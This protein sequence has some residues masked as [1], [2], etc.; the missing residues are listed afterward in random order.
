MTTALSGTSTRAE[1]DHQQQEAEAEHDGDEARQPLAEVVGEVDARGVDPPTWTSTSASPRAG[2]RRAG[3]GPVRSVASSCGAV[4]GT[5]MEMATSPASGDRR[6]GPRATL[7]VSRD[8]RR[9]ARRSSAGRR[10]RR[11]DGEHERPVGAGAEALGEQVV[12][13]A[14]GVWSSA[15]AGVA[16][17]EADREHGQ[18]E[19][20]QEQHAADGRGPGPVLDEAAPAVPERCSRRL[21]LAGGSCFAA[22][23]RR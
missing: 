11:L 14:G 8:G 3:G 9:G 12:G 17:A 2:R 18:G 23:W 13:P 1:H 4:S 15:V 19:E 10:R 22:T 5:T 7:S 6:A 16:E 20:Q 21:D